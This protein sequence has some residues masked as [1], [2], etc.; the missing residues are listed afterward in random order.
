MLKLQD[1]RAGTLPILQVLTKVVLN[2]KSIWWNL[3]LYKDILFLAFL[4]LFFF[5]PL[6]HL[7]LA[8]FSSISAFWSP[9]A[10]YYSSQSQI[11]PLLHLVLI[12]GEDYILL[13][14]VCQALC[15]RICVLSWGNS[16]AHFIYEAS[17]IQ[18]SYWLIQ[19]HTPTKGWG[20]SQ[21]PVSEASLL[22]HYI[23]VI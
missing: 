22:N 5:F 11:C 8:T 21:P 7:S 3:T 18:G 6:F 4:S 20:R 16:L 12:L 19:I 15:L 10:L 23:L 2:K 14:P 17:E 1:L 9:V 13:S